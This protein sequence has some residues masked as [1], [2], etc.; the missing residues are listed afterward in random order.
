MKSIYKLKKN[1]NEKS[2]FLCY[3]YFWWD[4]YFFCMTLRETFQ[5]S[6]KKLVIIFNIAINKN[7]KGWV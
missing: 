2:I 6:R 1:K 4:A 7:K 5:Q 3:D